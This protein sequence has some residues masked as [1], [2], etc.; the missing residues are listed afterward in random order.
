MSGSEA[1]LA[2]VESSTRTTKEV[3]CRVENGELV[4]QGTVAR[5]RTQRLPDN[6]R[7]RLRSMD[8]AIGTAVHS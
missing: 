7:R 5:S 6:T 8:G 1:L 4:G 2:G 3:L